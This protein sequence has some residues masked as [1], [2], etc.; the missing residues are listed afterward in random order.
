[1]QKKLWLLILAVILLLG[2]T[3]FEMRGED[4]NIYRYEWCPQ[5]WHDA[6]VD[7]EQSIYA[8][9]VQQDMDCI[10]GKRM[11]CWGDPAGG[12]PGGGPSGGGGPGAGGGK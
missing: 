11:D 10:D 5:C 1:M 6:W 9:R 12:G 2:C 8:A 7:V 4:G 3:A